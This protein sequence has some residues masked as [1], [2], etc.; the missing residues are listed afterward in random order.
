MPTTTRTA[1]LVS[2]LCSLSVVALGQTTTLSKDQKQALQGALTRIAMADALV[3]NM[4][5]NGMTFNEVQRVF[6]RQ[7]LSLQEHYMVENDK[8]IVKYG[9]GYANQCRIGN[10]IVFFS[11]PYSHQNPVVI[12]YSRFGESTIYENNL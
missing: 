6:D 5:Y 3:P 2:V 11:S 10:Y 1:L 12:G 4:V 8:Y 9:R 7:E